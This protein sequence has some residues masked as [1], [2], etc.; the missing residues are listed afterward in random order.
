MVWGLPPVTAPTPSAYVE[1][2]FG[3]APVPGPSAP[4]NNPVHNETRR[5][6]A[7]QEQVA[8]FFMNDGM[9]EQTCDGAC[10]PQ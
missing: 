6:P 9:V 1:I 3:I 8:R 2:D 7:V 4:S 5:L 10:D